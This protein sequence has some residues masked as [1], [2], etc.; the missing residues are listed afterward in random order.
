MRGYTRIL[1][2]L[3]IGIGATAF[4]PPSAFGISNLNPGLS[5]TSTALDAA[6]TV[7]NQGYFMMKTPYTPSSN[8][9]PGVAGLLPRGP[10]VAM[11][12]RV[13]NLHSRL[14]ALSTDLQRY[15]LLHSVLETDVN[16]YFATILS[17]VPKI[18]PLVYTPTVG[19]AC[20]NYSKI[21]TRQPKGIYLSRH[22]KG[23]IANVLR[24]WPF[25]DKVKVI[26]VTDGERILGLGDLGA[27]GM[28]IPVGKLALYTALGGIEPEGTLPMHIDFG[29]NVDKVRDDPLYMGL[30]ETRPDP[31]DAAAVKE[32][33]DFMEEY[34][35][36]VKEVYGRDCLVQFEDFG[37]GNAFRFLETF[38]DKHTC[39][40]DDI[41]GTASVVLGG[42]MASLRIT[43]GVEG[44]AKSL[45][46]HKFVFLGAGEAG[47]G[48]ATLI[49]ETIMV[50]N[51][52][53]TQEEAF[54]N[55][56]LVDS[57][58]LVTN[59]R[60]MNKLAH[61]KAPFAHSFDGKADT[62]LDAVKALGPS[63]IIGVSGQPQ[64]FTKEIVEHM[65]KINTRP[66]VFSLSNPTKKSE[67]TA[68]QAYTWSDGQAIFASG[69]PFPPVEF[70]GKTYTP[71]QGNN[72][73]V[74][75]GIG[76]G[77]VFSG[78]T[79]VDNTDMIVAA[80]TLAGLVPQK[81]LE[82]GACYPDLKTARDVSVKIA[83]EVA[84]WNYE[85]GTALNK[86]PDGDLEAAV[87]E[88]MWSAK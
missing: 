41:Q 40:N 72:A 58:G 55:I 48:I 28:G 87:R 38:T 51:P 83:V 29:C 31:K 15:S 21:H 65:A 34:F 46:D 12:V 42:V 32:Y 19:E 76:L 35:E 74:F 44:G 4:T 23:N 18:M 71:A 16:L 53:M 69:S 1:V 17:N 43:E 37:N 79:R 24:N 84:K 36:A 61:H 67:C 64:T 13:A 2:A 8:S 50:D 80:R 30:R 78:A 47:C 10:D 68:E 33:D 52:G 27:N 54:K 25:N 39:F 49:G 77:S 14:D 66:L 85:R 45:K 75:P 63:A 60:D 26:C 3:F 73:Y 88:S 82:A 57:Q 86:R 9:L 20:E 11:D 7:P 56:W 59:N 6:T 5:S 62:L 70:K 81:N 22:D